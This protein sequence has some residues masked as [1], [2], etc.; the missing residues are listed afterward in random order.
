VICT[1]MAA[2]T[3]LFAVL[4][5]VLGDDERCCLSPRLAPLHEFPDFLM[6]ALWC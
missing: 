3:R 1:G 2:A 4:D 6:V 5:C